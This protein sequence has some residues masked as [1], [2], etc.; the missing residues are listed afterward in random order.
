MLCEE[1]EG[2]FGIKF[3]EVWS[4]LVCVLDLNECEE[5]LSTCGANAECVNLPGSYRCECRDGFT[6]DGTTC[7]GDN[8]SNNN[9]DNN[10]N[11]NNN[12]H[13]GDLQY[14]KSSRSEKH[15]Q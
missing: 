15:M 5:N 2:C 9:N 11:N 13:N 10:I 12:N 6:G 1:V 7:T 14:I 4:N 8:N 3:Q